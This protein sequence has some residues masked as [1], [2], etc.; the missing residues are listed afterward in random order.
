MQAAVCVILVFGAP[1]A[2][3]Q[4]RHGKLFPP[5]NL[6]LLEGPD[7]D[8]WQK[9]DQ[10]MDALGI[11]DGSA[12]ADLGAGGGWF[13]IRLARRVGPN[14]VVYAEDIQ[15]QMLEATFR[16]VARE[17]LRNVRTVLGTADDPRLPLESLDAVLILDV[18]HEM[19]DPV[20][21]LRNLRRSLKPTGRVGIVDYKK[22]G[23]GPGPALEDRVEPDAI[24]RDATAA[25]LRLLKRETFL[26]YQFLLI[27]GP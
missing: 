5:Q 15:K 27:L 1:G 7:R 9:P 24:V 3:A 11:A 19:E 25:G 23:Y 14:G 21:L 6:G 2:S 16:R 13:T 18:Y 8:A 17:G 12:V 22:D 10:I 26:P 4:S 20:A